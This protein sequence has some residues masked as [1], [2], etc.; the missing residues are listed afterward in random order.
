[1]TPT[2]RPSIVLLFLD[3]CPSAIIRTI[4]AHIIDAFYHHAFWTWPHVCH[5]LRKA[6]LPCIANGNAS[7]A[8]VRII[9]HL[10]AIASAFHTQPYAVFSSFRHA[11]NTTPLARGFV[12]QASATT[13]FAGSQ[14]HSTNKNLVPAFAMTNPN[15]LLIGSLW[16]HAVNEQASEGLAGM[17]NQMR[18]T[19]YTLS[20]AAL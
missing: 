20:R 5:E 14:L 10:R 15:C 12:S 19:P 4:A 2:S 18:H 17:V 1:M 11:V 16:G 7:A 13:C 3:C 9:S 6:S 8:V